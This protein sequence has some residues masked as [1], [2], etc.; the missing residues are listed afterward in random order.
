MSTIGHLLRSALVAFTAVVTLSAGTTAAM[1]APASSLSA[2][3][4]RTVADD[5][6]STLADDGPSTVADD[7]VEVTLD[8]DEITVNVPQS[9]ME[10][11]QKDAEASGDI[12]AQGHKSF[13]HTFSHKTS[14]KIYNAIN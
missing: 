10:Q 3:G 11:A 13:S 8:G 4:A 9:L 1:A 7:G 6:P 2:A 12:S 14:K 5:D